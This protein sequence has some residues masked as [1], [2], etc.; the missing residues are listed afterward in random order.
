ME[1]PAYKKT[2]A[3]VKALA[4]DVAQENAIPVEV[5]ASKK[6]MNQA[7]K[8]Y[9]LTIDETRAQ[10]LQPDLLSGWRGRLFGDRLTQLLDNA[11]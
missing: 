3:K 2:L 10:G 1:F 8:W 5:V 9:W 6:Q 4:G 7:I 11:K